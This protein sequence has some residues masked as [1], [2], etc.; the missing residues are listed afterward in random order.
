MSNVRQSI[1]RRLTWMNMLVSGCALLLACTSF[2]G[3]DLFA[4]RERMQANLSAQAQ[5][6]G[7]NSASAVLFNDPRTAAET[8][9]A[10]KASPDIV[11]AQTYTNDGRLFASYWRTGTRQQAAPPHLLP[12]QLETFSTDLRSVELARRIVFEGM[13]IGVV[14]IQSD[15]HSMYLQ[16]ERYGLIVVGVLLCSF[17]A[18][19]VVSRVAQRTISRPLGEVADIARRVS[20]QN[21]FSA[22]APRVESMY[23]L[24]ILI[25]SFNMMLDE[26]Q[27]RDRSLNRARVELEERVQQRTEELHATNSELE[28]FSYSVSHDLRA[29]LRHITGFASLLEQHAGEH[30][31]EQGRKYLKTI[32]DATARMSKLIDDLLAFSRMGR[33][34][35]SKRRVNLAALVEDARAEV[36]HDVDGRCVRWTV[37][38][39]PPVEAD[40]ALLR[41]VLVNLLSNAI[42]YTRTR[43]EA[44]IE[45]GAYTSEGRELVVFVR[46]NGVGFDMA[47]AHKLFGVFQRLHRADEF[48]GTGIGL[49]N[50][51]RIV[52]RH[53]GRT[54]ADGVVDQGA[55]FYFSLPESNIH[56]QGV[57]A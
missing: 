10:L 29:P 37:H 22:R 54:W 1:S 53:G 20:Q 47:Y 15:V 19:L 3:Y 44:V 23:E 30:F 36:S 40:P 56:S 8:L 9:A 46:D 6:V 38:P 24:S 12:G 39:L 26:I 51:R 52:Q 27:Q 28:A 11:T 13:P 34:N 41:P 7:A 4:F 16:L 35:L 17:M 21:D 48:S 50:V 57:P 31:D 25:D 43:E 32:T 42:K 18:A 14:R 49:A 2:V 33:T 5:I 55:T 45:I